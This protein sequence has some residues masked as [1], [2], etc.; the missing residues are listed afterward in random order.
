MFNC[1]IYEFYNMKLIK[2]LNSVIS[3]KYCPKSAFSQ[4]IQD[5]KL[6]IHSFFQLILLFLLYY[7]VSMVNFE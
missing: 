2:K 6:L 3:K 4:L 1:L 7:L 5:L